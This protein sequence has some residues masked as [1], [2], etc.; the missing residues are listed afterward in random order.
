MPQREITYLRDK[1]TKERLLE[2][3][4]R[5]FAQRGFR[6]TTVGD[7]EELAGLAPRS[8]AMYK[9]F[10]N[11]RE[12]L[13]AAVERHLHEVETIRN[14]LDLMPLGDLRAELMLLARWILADLDRNR[15]LFL[16]FEKEG[17]NLA[18]LRDRYYEDVGEFG[19]RIG[20]EFLRRALDAAKADIDPEVLVTVTMNALV[21]QRRCEWTFGR[22]PLGLD[23][24]QLV[25][26]VV[27]IVMRFA[28]DDRTP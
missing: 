7:I 5:L 10:A 23:D 27:E 2:A 6:R 22:K 25:E 28:T 19:Y 26:G 3:G 12:L 24:G 8:G 21:N 11:K 13:A 15:E 17:D 14:V 18:D 16:V 20:A 4:L 1:A 9:H